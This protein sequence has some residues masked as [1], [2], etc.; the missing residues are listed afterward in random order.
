MVRMLIDYARVHDKPTTE[1]GQRSAFIEFK[2]FGLILA[3]AYD[4]AMKKCSLQSDEEERPILPCLYEG[5]LEAPIS[6]SK[7][8]ATFNM[9]LEY[10]V[11]PPSKI[12]INPTVLLDG[13][14]VQLEEVKFFECAQPG[15]IR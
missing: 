2:A 15:M 8:W 7:S 6:F 1:R 11:P 13:V 9:A 12:L 14:G 4:I 5:S 3:N 10:I